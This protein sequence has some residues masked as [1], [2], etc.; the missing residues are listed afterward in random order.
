[1]NGLIHSQINEFPITG[2]AL[3]QQW[4]AYSVSPCEALHHAKTWQKTLTRC[5]AGAGIL[6]NFQNCKLS[7]S[8]LYKSHLSYSVIAI[9]NRLKLLLFLKRKI[10]SW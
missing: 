4:L 10:T 6:L 2:V 3:M 8:F 7:K 9:E 5:Q 1:M